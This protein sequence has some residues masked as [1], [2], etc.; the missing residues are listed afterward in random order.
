[1]RAFA[2]IGVFVEMRAVEEGQAVRVAREMRGRPIE[3]HPDAFLVAAVNEVHKIFWRSEAAGDGEITDRL[4]SPGFIERMLHHRNHLDMRVAHSLDV[5][6]Q[7]TGEFAICQPAV[8]FIWLSPP[9]SKM[10]LID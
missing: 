10:Q 5:R 8:A 6:N 4:I 9:R 7:F 3:N 2:R 1:M